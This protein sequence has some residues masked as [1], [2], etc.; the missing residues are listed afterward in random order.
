MVSFSKFLVGQRNSRQLLDTDGYIYVR[1]KAKDTSTTTAWLCTKQRSLKCPCH[2]YLS[3]SDD[4]LAQGAKSHNHDPDKQ[5][6]QKRE[7]ITSLKRKAEDQQLSA[8]Q[9]LITEVL[10]TSTPEL[11]VELPKLES[12]AR[13][14]QRSRAKASG[15]S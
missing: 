5:T 9:N 13:V 11:N 14:V 15:V 6:E 2:V 10:V 4:S 7:L 8:T 3:L 12:L 1:K